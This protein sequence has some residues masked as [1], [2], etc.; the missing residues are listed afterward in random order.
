MILIDGRKVQ[1]EG[2]NALLKAELAVAIAQIRSRI[3]SMG[4]AED[5]VDRLIR[6]A[7]ADAKVYELSHV[8]S[9]A[10]MY[11]NVERYY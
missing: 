6:E 8:K 11:A 5:V 10:E 9:E 2:S 3:L 4:L 1:I 7:V